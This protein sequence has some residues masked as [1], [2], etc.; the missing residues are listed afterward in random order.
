MNAELLTKQYIEHEVKLRVMNEV[1]GARFKVIEG[2]IND[3]KTMW[4]VTIG[5][6]ITSILLPVV[7]H[8]FKL[9]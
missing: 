9:V 4:K 1:N 2:S 3:I 7:L 6:A 5:V 8:F